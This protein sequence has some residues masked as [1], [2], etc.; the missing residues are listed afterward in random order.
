MSASRLYPWGLR[1]LSVWGILLVAFALPYLPPGPPLA[2]FESWPR[3]HEQ[4][5]RLVAAYGFD[6]SLPVQYGLWMQRLVTG[7]WG[8]SRFY[9]RPVFHDVLRATGSTLVLLLWTALVYSVWLALCKAGRCLLLGRGSSPSNGRYLLF[10][11]TLPTFLVAV[12][13]HDIAIWHLGWVT[14][15]NVALFAPYHYLNPIIMFLPASVLA[16]TPLIHWHTRGQHVQMDCAQ[17]HWQRLG[18]HWRQLCS[19]LHPLLGFFLMEVL[20][21]EYVFA[22]PG[23]G[24]FGVDVVKRRDFA[25]IQGFIVSLGV[26]YLLLHS[27]FKAGA[28]HRTDSDTPDIP[29]TR[30][31]L[32]S[33]IWGL[34][35]LLSLTLWASQLWLYDP[36]EIHTR[37][38]LLRPN[39]RYILGTDFLGRDVLSR[40]LA[41]FRSTMPRILVVTTL[42]AVASGLLLSMCWMLPDRLKGVWHA[43]LAVFEALPPF[44]LAL[45]AYVVVSHVSWPL[46]TAF[47]IACVPITLQLASRRRAWLHQL[48]TLAYVAELVLLLHVSFF[49]LNLIPEPISPTWGGDIRIGVNYSHVNIWLVLAPTLAVSW[50][51]LVFRKLGVYSALPPTVVPLAATPVW[52]ATAAGR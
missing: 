30:R 25:A 5:Q 38:Q 50:S 32:F 21:T 15:T 46:E 39:A 16:L 42:T 14:L 13:V 22:L 47:T 27:M 24:R 10:L 2:V 41:G 44:L 35:L 31:A 17:S 29:D 28:K 12:I 33:S 34:L 4:R 26:L 45:L 20:L 19:V 18:R 36:T 43:S 49:Y 51:R 48:A 37:D 11:E 6:R 40:A 7:Q 3:D 8:T 9:N 23:L 52:S 1:L